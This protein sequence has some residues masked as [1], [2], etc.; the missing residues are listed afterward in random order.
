MEVAR[1]TGTVRGGA[2]IYKVIARISP[3]DVE[4]TAAQIH[5][6][7]ILLQDIIVTANMYLS[8]G[9]LLVLYF[10]EFVD[11]HNR[12]LV[13]ATA[14]EAVRDIPLLAFVPHNAVVESGGIGDVEDIESD[15]D[16]WLGWSCCANSPAVPLR[17]WTEGRVELMEPVM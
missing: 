1:E 5:D 2:G 12:D 10:A 8:N 13:E 17:A 11:N 15:E 14:R 16:M 6:N 4:L 9:L 3:N 7:C